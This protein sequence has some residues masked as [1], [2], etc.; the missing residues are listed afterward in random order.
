MDSELQY[1]I[2]YHTPFLAGL[3]F[4]QAIACALS[5]L[6]KSCLKI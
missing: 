6:V 5:L 3:L 1:R 2:V 4:V